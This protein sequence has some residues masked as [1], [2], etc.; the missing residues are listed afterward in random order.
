MEKNLQHNIGSIMDAIE[1]G[2]YLI[3]KNYE[4]EYM[5]SAMVKVHGDGLGKKCYE[6]FNHSKKKCSWCRAEEIFEKESPIRWEFYSSRRQKKYL[7]TEMPV[8]HESGK[9]SKLTI[10]RDITSSNEY[11]EM[12]KASQQDFKRL[13]ESVACGVYISSTEGKFIDANS[14]LLKML[15]YKDKEKFLELDLA[16]DVY[17]SP[18]KRNKLMDIIE[19]N[20]Q[21]EGFDVDFKCNGG[22]TIPVTITGHARY[23]DDNKICGY[24]G[25]IVNQSRRKKMEK[26]INEAHDYLKKIIQNSPNPI[27]AA[28]MQ[29]VITV[30]NTT[31]E[32]TLGYKSEDVVGK[33]NIVQ[34]YED[35]RAGEVMKILRS[36]QYGEKGIINSYPLVYIRS[37]KRVVEANLSAAIIYDDGGRELASVGIFVDLEERLAMEKSLRDTQEQLFQSEKLAAMGRLTSQIAHELNNPLFGIMNTFELLKT[38]I[39]VTNKRRKILEMAL[40]ET[41]R[42][43][44]MLRKML[45]FSKPEE[46]KKQLICINSVIDEIL[47]LHDKQLR[48][49]DIKL[50]YNFN[51]NIES[52]YASKNHL[53]QVFL[54]LLSNA[55]DAMPE[56]G[57]LHFETNL[58]S[59]QVIVTVADTGIGI[60]EENLGKIF[61]SFFTTKGS[62]QGVGLGLSVCYGLIVD[63][64]GDIKV[65]SEVNK[66]TTFTINLPVFD[67]A[68]LEKGMQF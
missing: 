14:A 60:K 15:N 30:W 20:G 21:A 40:S 68:S 13:F 64:G 63:H 31:A 61:D 3:N 52:I 56:G 49:N 26:E 44:E 47:L 6:V 39:P 2:V 11:K 27:I 66:G 53:R 54:N 62:L 4:I 43:A 33:M 45:S 41:Q 36:D 46:E 48:E 34:F 25:I 59:N 58:V 19:K 50:T 32:K 12:F 8:R 16:N 67:E 38:E 5:N 24:E 28:N 17:E 9:V 35:G 7:L 65:E 42:L 18:E 23:D 1:E 57:S 29:G 55:K 51:E 10:S 22:G 37:D